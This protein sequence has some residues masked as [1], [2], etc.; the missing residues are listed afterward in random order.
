[1]TYPELY[2]S[3]VLQRR[4]EQGIAALGECR[5]CPRRCGAN[6]REDEVGFCGV[7]RHS[8][9]ASFNPHFG[10]EQPL[11]GTHGSGTIF[12][13]GCNLGC[14]FCQN[15]DISHNPGAGLKAE[16]EE[17]AGV[18]LKLQEQGCHNINFVTPSH[19][20]VQ[21]LEALPIA[22]EHGLR[23]P[24][25]YNTSSYDSLEV[26]RLLDGV[27]DIYMPDVKIW[28]VENAKR[29]LRA[30]DYPECARAAVTEMHR[31]VGDLIIDADGVAQR[32]LLVR[33]LVM[34][35]DI[36]GTGEWMAFLAGLSK[37]TYVNIMDQY[38]PCF[39]AADYPEINRMISADELSAARVEAE[40]CGLT[41]LDARSERFFH[42]L[43]RKSH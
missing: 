9:V 41:R 35:E 4:I 6:R 1:M 7:G 12:F 18:M 36:V 29:Y 40:K 24:L 42:R 32:G 17:L 39:H 26:L 19:V 2:E 33:H 22:I 37:R 11:V 14:R 30:K 3:G 20:A 38:R 16:P 28:D 31:Q 25:V 8:V 23:V 15:H 5:L 34:P 21:I 43:F 10:E 27:V 13:A